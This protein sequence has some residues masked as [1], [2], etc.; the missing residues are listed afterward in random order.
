MCAV[1]QMHLLE[2]SREGIVPHADY[3]I[4]KDRDNHNNNNKNNNNSNDRYNGKDGGN[5]I[6]NTTSGQ[7]YSYLES[8]QRQNNIKGSPIV[9]NNTVPFNSIP[10]RSPHL[11]DK[12]RTHGHLILSYF[13]SFFFLTK[14]L[15]TLL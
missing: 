10:E 4:F 5:S 6:N 11:N 13:R 3:D 15:T 2:A 14:T 8:F 1:I 7:R 12:V 9:V